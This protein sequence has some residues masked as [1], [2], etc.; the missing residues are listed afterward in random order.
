VSVVAYVVALSDVDEAIELI[1]KRVA[2]PGDLVE[3]V[4][5][6]SDALLGA[7]H[8]QRGDFTRA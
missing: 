8:L 4:A 5:P 7:L 6:V 3:D 1:K 2:T